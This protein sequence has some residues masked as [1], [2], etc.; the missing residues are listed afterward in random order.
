MGEWDPSTNVCLYVVSSL[1]QLNPNLFGNAFL[2]LAK[3]GSLTP[4]ERLKRQVVVVI[5]ESNTLGLSHSDLDA[6]RQKALDKINLQNKPF[7][8]DTSLNGLP[9]GIVGKVFF[10]PQKAIGNSENVK[11]FKEALKDPT[12]GQFTLEGL[13]KGWK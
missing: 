5:Y 8:L 4:Q 2:K 7:F 11:V 9:D 6:Y 12:T 10:A 3:L 13:K 1:N